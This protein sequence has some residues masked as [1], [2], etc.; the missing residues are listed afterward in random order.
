MNKLATPSNDATFKSIR[1]NV[2]T[3]KPM[4]CLTLWPNRSLSQD[5]FRI[6]LGIVGVLIFLPFIPLL[7]QATTAALLLFPLATFLLLYT[8]FRKNYQDGKLVEVLKVFPSEISVSR[9]S[10][11]GHTKDW[12]ANPY[13]TKVKL[14]NKKGLVE[15]YL[16]LSG[17]GREI[18]LGAFLTP[19][20]RISIKEKIDEVLSLIRSNAVFQ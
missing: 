19:E 1:E 9:E 7:M 17:N 16:T 13:W 2:G 4:I 18:E 6:F 3:A 15:N 8:A 20:E 10:T 14:H 12:S 11:N 5:N